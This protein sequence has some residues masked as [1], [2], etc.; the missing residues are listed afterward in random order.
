MNLS[1]YFKSKL[2]GTA[3]C[4]YIEKLK[5][6]GLTTDPY[7]MKDEVWDAN[8]TTIPNIRQWDISVYMI[9]TPSPYTKQ[10]TKVIIVGIIV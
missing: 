3:R 4:R 7:C 1:E 5:K 2:K 8:P 10:A 9:H 6:C